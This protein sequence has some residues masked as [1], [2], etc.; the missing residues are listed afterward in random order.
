LDD[1][2]N[3]LFGVQGLLG[4]KRVLDRAIGYKKTGL[5]VNSNEKVSPKKLQD[6]Q[7][8]TADKL[9]KDNPDRFKGKD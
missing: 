2:R 7:K 1:Y 4:S 5:P 3:I 6:L 8:Q 9:V